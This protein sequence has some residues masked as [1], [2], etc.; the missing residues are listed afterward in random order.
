MG[1]IASVTSTFSFPLAAGTCFYLTKGMRHPELA[2]RSRRYGLGLA[3]PL[4]VRFVRRGFSCRTDMCDA[5]CDISL[6][7]LIG[8]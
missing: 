1:I 3:H 5:V 4:P 6:N 8:S 7:Y 2:R